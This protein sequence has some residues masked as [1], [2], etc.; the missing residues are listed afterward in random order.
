MKTI[1]ELIRDSNLTRTRFF[2]EINKP[3]KIVSRD[4]SLTPN[5]LN[6]KKDSSLCCRCFYLQATPE[7]LE[8]DFK[9][10]IRWL[11]THV[12]A[13][14]VIAL[15][16]FNK[17]PYILDYDVP[18]EK[19]IFNLY[20]CKNLCKETGTCLSYDSR[21]YLC[22]EFT[23]NKDYCEKCTTKP[24]CNGVKS[25]TLDQQISKEI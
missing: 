24:Y 19:K 25:E 22:R 11:E 10:H 8:E 13:K 23:Y 20:T 16:E 17:N 7:E 2:Q 21:P 18:N 5:P 9:K 4:S 15:G 3:F 14:I 1:D 12:I 6:G